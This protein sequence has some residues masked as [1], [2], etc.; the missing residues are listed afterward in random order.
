MASLKAKEIEKN[1]YE[2]QFVIEKAVF[3]EEVNKVY[4]KNAPKINV[5]GFRRGKAPKHIIEKMY[6]SAVFYDEAIDNLLPE[7][8]SNALAETKLEAVSRPEIDIVSIDDAGVTLKAAVYTKPEVKIS[9]YKGLEVERESVNVT[10]E[11]I[12]KEIETVRERNSRMLTVEDRASQNGDEATIDFEGFVDGVAFEG[13]KGEKY[14]LKLGS[15]SFIP[16]FEDQIIG[17]KPGDEFD[18]TVKFP[19]DY[20]AEN[21]AGKESVFKIKLHELKVKELPEVD[22][23]FV[24]DVSEFNTIAEYREDVKKK[25][26]ER[27]EHEADHKFEHAVLHALLEKTEADIPKVMI[28]QEIDGYIRDYEYRLKAQGGSLDMYYKYTGMKPE[29]LR[30]SFRGEA[31]EQVKTRLALGEVAKKEK[32]KALKKDIEAEYKKIAEGYNV[33]V[34]TVKNS[35]SEESITED[36]VLRKASE[37][38]RDNAVVKQK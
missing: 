3:D 26:T 10:E 18:I 25:I 11:D 16:G 15:G 17:H 9:E 32:I 38:V 35:V 23:E 31:E 29:Q 22:D 37:F 28:E 2:F 36:I 19:D 12:D 13:G 21:L 33:D 27:R 5:P 20:G 14:P 1:K 34:D 8:Y 4:R 24:K 30:D 6:G 7:A